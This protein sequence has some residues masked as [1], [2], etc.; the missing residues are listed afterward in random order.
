MCVIVH[1]SHTEPDLISAAYRAGT[2]GYGIKGSTESL[3]A[4]V[5][6]V[7]GPVRKPFNTAIPAYRRPCR[8][9]FMPLPYQ[10]V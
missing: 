7:V 6:T 9:R 2:A 1:S 4:S 5:R 10:N 3:V 8:E